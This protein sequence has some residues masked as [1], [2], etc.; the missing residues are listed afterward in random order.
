MQ[1]CQDAV[2]FLMGLLKEGYFCEDIADLQ[3]MNHKF[4]D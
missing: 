4:S 2:H 3:A 1:R